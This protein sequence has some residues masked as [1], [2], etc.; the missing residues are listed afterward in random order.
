MATFLRDMN[1]QE[2]ALYDRDA[3]RYPWLKSITMTDDEMR[4]RLDQ[5]FYE[6]YTEKIFLDLWNLHYT[7]VYMAKIKY[8]L[9]TGEYVLYDMGYLDGQAD[10]IISQIMEADG[11]DKDTIFDVLCRKKK[12]TFKQ[13][14]SN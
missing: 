4:I 7:W 11:A 1:E 10:Y 9:E 14:V 2:Q 13:S 5:Y 12:Y 8:F 3:I 6:G